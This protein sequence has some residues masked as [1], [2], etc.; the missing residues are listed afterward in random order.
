MAAFRW[1][2]W[3]MAGSVAG[4]SRDGGTPARRAADISGPA[5]VRPRE[6]LRYSLPWVAIL[7]ITAGFHFFRGVPVDGWIFLTAGLVLGADTA[8]RQVRQKSAAASTGGGA[9]RGAAGPAHLAEAEGRQLRLSGRGMLWTML[10][11]G[12][13]A[14]V[15]VVLAPPGSLGI[16]AV[17][18]LVGAGMLVVAWPQTLRPAQPHPEEP[19]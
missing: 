14:A 16:P 13:G 17:V 4:S 18:G 10:V 12:A 15:V 2:T 8:L 11:V 19:A 3:N 7:F 6:Q 1:W 5:P 9:A